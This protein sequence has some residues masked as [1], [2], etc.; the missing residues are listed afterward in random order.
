[1]LFNILSEAGH[2][3]LQATKAMRAVET[4]LA[5]NHIDLLIADLIL[6]DISGVVL[7]ERLRAAAPTVPIIIVCG[8]FSPESHSTRAELSKLGVVSILEKPVVRSALLDAVGV[9][10]G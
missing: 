8:Y 4:L 6:P 3:V 1:M 9:S 7:I 5:P 10:L 2:E